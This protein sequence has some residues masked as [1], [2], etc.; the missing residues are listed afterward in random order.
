MTAAF[1]TARGKVGALT[2][3][4]EQI[5]ES[6]KSAKASKL[7][8]LNEAKAETYERRLAR[9][10]TASSRGSSITTT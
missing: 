4:L 9:R 10:Q 3:Q 8:D 1:Q 2:Y 7:K 6:D 5:P